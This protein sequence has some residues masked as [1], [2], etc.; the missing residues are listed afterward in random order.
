MNAIL[1]EPGLEPMP[2]TFTMSDARIFTGIESDE[3]LVPITN[4]MMAW[5]GVLWIPDQTIF[6][7]NARPWFFGAQFLVG[8][9]VFAFS[10]EWPEDVGDVPEVMWRT[11]A[12]MMEDAITL[13]PGELA[14]DAEKILR[15]ICTRS[16]VTTAAG[17]IEWRVRESQ[18]DDDIHSLLRRI[19]L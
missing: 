7:P 3:G 9:A 10:P 17:L 13:V 14:P 6:R 1:I 15:R 4:T 16:R 19:K 2:T 12:R 5:L 8:P 11:A 18:I